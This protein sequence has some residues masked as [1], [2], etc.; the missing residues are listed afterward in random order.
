L[1]HDPQRLLDSIAR[2]DRQARILAAVVR[3]LLAMLRAS[4]F[5]LVSRRLPDGAAKADILRAIESA[6]PFLPLAIILRVL[7]LE[8]AHYYAWRRDAVVCDL[9]DRPSCPRTNPG[10]LTAAE[11]A[12]IKSMVLTPNAHRTQVAWALHISQYVVKFHVTVKPRR[13]S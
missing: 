4:G 13:C 2:L 8:P 5:S 7:R 11:V 10:Q 12:T 3:L 9:D 6:Q 1:D